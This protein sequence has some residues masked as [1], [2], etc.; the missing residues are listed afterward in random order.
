MEPRANLATS[1]AVILLHFPLT[2]SAISVGKRGG[3]RRDFFKKAPPTARQDLQGLGGPL[4]Q[5]WIHSQWALQQQ[6]LR[7]A[8]SLGMTPALPAF[9]V[10]T[11]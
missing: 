7:R 4:P 10:C 3:H 1:G 8:R 9:Q 11:L 6:I 5:S 2:S